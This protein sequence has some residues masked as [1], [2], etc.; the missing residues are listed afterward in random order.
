[1][2]VYNSL[3]RS[4]EELRTIEPGHVKLYTCG[5]TVYNFAHI[6]NFRAYTFEDVLRR[7]LL[8]NGFRVTQVMNL[9]DVD[10][11]TI[12]G[13][14]AA[15]VPLK[16]FTQPY[17][18]A[19]FDDL[20]T[21]N[22]QPAEHYPAA[23]DHIA[24]MIALVAKLFERGLA[25]TSEDG[26]VYFSVGKLQG[27]GKL[28]HLD[29]E[30]LRAGARVAQDEYEKESY[31]D[32]ALWKGWD[33]SDGDVV[34]ESPWG[35]GRPGWHLEC[36]AMSMR[37]L[38]ETFD[39][40]TGGIDNLFPHHENEIAQAEGATGKPFVT[41]WMHCAHLRVNG[42]K[43]SKSLGNFFTLRDLVEKGWSGREIRTVLIN[44]HYR[45]ALNFTFDALDA[46]RAAL[47]RVDE[48]VDAL[49]E[50][51]AGAATDEGAPGWAAEAH[52]AFKAAVNDDLNMPEAFAALFALVRGSNSALRAGALAATDAA[53]LLALADR[54]DSVLGVIR[55]GRAD[56]AEAVPA[57]VTALAEARAA[58]RAAKDWAESDRLR[59]ELATKG[60]EVRDSKEGQKLKKL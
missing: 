13:S 19:F 57:A 15:G 11:K 46:A 2:Q 25:Y 38:G 26:S 23:T 31:G 27:Y 21:L 18:Q 12:R 1:M 43:M 29:R 33:A 53:A 52:D 16:S 58:A 44:G 28:A 47:A 41:Y 51:A 42:E 48:C 30:N 8:F 5:P 32:F 34:W 17:I 20:K 36:S 10:D 37:Y 45:Q 40:H 60:W 54:M 7:A 24:E 39:L 4:K 3:S 49:G 14:L 9:T 55:F 50:R 59:D 56:R 6:G 35:R 22:I